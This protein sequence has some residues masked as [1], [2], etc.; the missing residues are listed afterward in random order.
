MVMCPEEKETTI[1][2][3]KQR[4]PPV[5]AAVDSPANSRPPTNLIPSLS[6]SL[7]AFW[8]LI[9]AGSYFGEPRIFPV[10]FITQDLCACQLCRL[11]AKDTNVSLAGRRVSRPHVGTDHVAAAMQ[12]STLA[13]THTRP[14]QRVSA[15]GCE[16]SRCSRGLEVS[17]YQTAWQ[18]RVSN[19]LPSWAIADLTPGYV[20]GRHLPETSVCQTLVKLDTSILH[21]TN[22][23]HGHPIHISSNHGSQALSHVWCVSFAHTV[24]LDFANMWAVTAEF[25]DCRNH[26]NCFFQSS[27]F[28][29]ITS[30]ERASP[31]PKRN[32]MRFP[33]K[34]IVRRATS[35]PTPRHPSSETSS[36]FEVT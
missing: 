8:D 30:H 31:E 3:K 21:S 10:A 25:H 26:Q 19:A 28:P 11:S 15:S 2:K 14:H 7:L 32:A 24:R 20:G 16:R 5:P 22:T 27:L 13:A 6:P 34:P 23:C 1:E 29:C 9:W 12:R 17:S 4:D 18:S 33:A 35:H 36:N